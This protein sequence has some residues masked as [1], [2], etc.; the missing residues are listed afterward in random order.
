LLLYIALAINVQK[1]I[2][3]FLLFSFEAVSKYFPLKAEFKIK[4]GD[5]A[6]AGLTT[7]IH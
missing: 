2:L 6:M 5:P 4:K 3:R 7:K 1:N